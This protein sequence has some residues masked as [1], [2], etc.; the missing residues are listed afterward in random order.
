M[1]NVKDYKQREGKD[2]EPFFVLVLQ[3]DVTPVKSKQSGRLYF[4]A[5]TCTVSSTFDEQTCKDL[6][7][8]QFPGENYPGHKTLSK[9]VRFR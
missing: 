8:L 7:G 9:C 4:T 6:I 1:V 5:K 2:G 3:G